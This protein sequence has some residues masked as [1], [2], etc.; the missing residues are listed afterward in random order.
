MLDWSHPLDE[1][2]FLVHQES[3]RH[4][5]L[6]DDIVVVIVIII[7]IVIVIIIIIIVVVIIII[8]CCHFAR[9]RRMWIH[10]VIDMFLDF[11]FRCESS[12]TVWHWAAEWTIAY[13]VCSCVLV[14][15][16]LLSEVLATLR[17][18]VW[19]FSGVNSDVHM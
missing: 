10:M 7:C 16:G 12:P 2:G 8:Q 17:A 5:L 14:Q 3:W 15:D 9:F 6:Q 1:I 11:L 13:L 4:F 19:F 18:F